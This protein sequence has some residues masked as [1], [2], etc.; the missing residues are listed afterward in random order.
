[1]K[2]I[3]LSILFFWM[4][5]SQMKA[6]SKWALEDLSV[7]TFRNG[8]VLFHVQSLQD[9]QL[10]NQ[11]KLPA[12]YKIGIGRGSVFYNFYA[13]TDSRGL[14][15]EGYK[16]ATQNDLSVL[17]D[18]SYYQAPNN[19][20]KTRGKGA[21]FFAEPNGYLPYENVVLTNRSYAGY[22]WISSNEDEEMSKVFIFK[23]D[24][25]GFTVEERPKEEFYS[26]R[27]VANENEMNEFNKTESK[28]LQSEKFVNYK[29]IAA[30]D[31]KIAIQKEVGKELSDEKEQVSEY[32]SS[33]E[34]QISTKNILLDS[35]K[36]NQKENVLA[37]G[38]IEE[39]DKERE[40]RRKME[41]KETETKANLPKIKYNQ[42]TSKQYKKTE[43]RLKQLALHHSC[44]NL[45]FW[46]SSDLE[47]GYINVTIDGNKQTILNSYEKEPSSGA[48]GCAVFSC[49]KPGKY[50]VN[51][52]CYNLQENL[53]IEIKK[54]ECRKIHVTD[55][56]FSKIP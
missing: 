14:A 11:N 48:E 53:I 4:S 24:L 37:L 3:I 52:E 10:C 25:P 55:S 21:S 19:S 47:C 35:L 23:N 22:Y 33:V 42:E 41:L 8:D 34:Q 43:K 54:G 31:E 38:N 27:C 7:T 36:N 44:S 29:K 45:L 6:Q 30:L 20:W 40:E 18:S 15:P 2:F 26:V 1:M 49:L 5:I 32:L 50:L 12:Y 39:V 16:L 17:T 51:L 56:I 46:V 28:L 9:L 13:L